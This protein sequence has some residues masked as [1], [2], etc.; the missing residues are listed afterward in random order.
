MINKERGNFNLSNKFQY[1]SDIKG[2]AIAC[3]EPVD[4]K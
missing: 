2:G 4:P 3:K 1:G